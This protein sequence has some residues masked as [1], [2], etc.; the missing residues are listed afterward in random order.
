MRLGRFFSLVRLGALLLTFLAT[1]V[2]ALLAQTAAA[3]PEQHRP[4]S[5]PYTGD[6]S[7]LGK[8]PGVTRGSISIR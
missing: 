7:I 3:Q 4:T 1:P 5:T 6:L 8:F 2:P